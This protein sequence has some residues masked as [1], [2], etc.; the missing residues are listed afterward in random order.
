MGEVDT[1]CPRKLTPRKSDFFLIEKYFEDA[2]QDKKHVPDLLEAIIQPP[3]LVKEESGQKLFKMMQFRP[4]ITK[5]RVCNFQMSG[6]IL[7][8]TNVAFEAVI[9]THSHPFSQYLAQPN[10]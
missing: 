8:S 1:V 7:D 6:K 2:R 4:E 9:L 10:I 3:G 5:F